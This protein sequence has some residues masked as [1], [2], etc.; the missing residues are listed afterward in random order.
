LRLLRVRDFDLTQGTVVIHGKGGKVKV[1]PIG[2]DD[3]KADLHL[4]VLAREPDEY[5][6]Y[7]KSSPER[8]FD[9][10]SL[11]RWFKKALERAGLPHNIKIHEL[12]H[13]AADNLWRETGNLL[14][15]QQLLRHE[16]VATTQQYLH[17]T[18]DDLDDALARLQV[19]RSEEAGNEQ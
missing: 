6:I 16:S 11:H 17:P 9:P 13:S 7:P 8:P 2:F 3:L 5:L 4:E 14:L 10:A 12:R 15:A 18:R 1:M 19:V